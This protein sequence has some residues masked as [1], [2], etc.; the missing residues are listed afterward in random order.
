[1]TKI[2]CFN[3]KNSV[4]I[5]FLNSLDMFFSV[6]IIYFLIL[7][8]Y[9][10]V[11][12]EYYNQ[13]EKFLSIIFLVFSLTIFIYSL[14]SLF[15]L[16]NNSFQ[17]IMINF[18]FVIGIITF[19]FSIYFF[20]IFLFLIQNCFQKLSNDSNVN[21][22]DI[23]F[24]KFKDNEEDLKNLR[25]I[26]IWYLCTIIMVFFILIFGFNLK[27]LKFEKGDENNE[28]DMVVISTWRRRS[29]LNKELN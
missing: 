19:V 27:M 5:G 15:N 26:F 7:L 20:T 8:Q 23:L 10:K 1:M 14:I 21:F 11:I 17:K 29:S 18:R 12:E 24:P 22:I 4:F 28:H 16:K 6:F 13:H 25:E 9:S 2:L 3:V